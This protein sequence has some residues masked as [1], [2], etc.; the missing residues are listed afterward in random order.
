MIEPRELA[1]GV[2]LTA[3]TGAPSEFAGCVLFSRDGDSVETV[4]AC[5][6]VL[7][8][9]GRP[10][11][12]IDQEG[13]RVARIRRGVEALPSMMALGAIGDAE[14]ATRAGEAVAHDLRRA[15]CT[16]DF[17]P[18]L[19]LALEPENTVIG[20]RA[21]GS[22][23]AFVAR[24]GAAFARG[25]RNGGIVP[26][27]KHFPGHGST[28]I[29]S[30]LALPVIDI[31]EATL[32]ARDLAP[33]AAVAAH[34]DPIMVSHVVARALDPDRPASL[35]ARIIRG[36]LRDEWG[37]DG[38]VFTDCMQMDAIARG[39]GTVQ[40]V[41]AAIAAGAD[42]ALVSHVEALASAC[43]D[44]L[45]A[46]VESGSLAYE[47][48][49]EAYE[50]VLRLRRNS[51]AP[52]ALD[53]PAPHPGVGA[54]IARRAVTLV[55]GDSRADASTTVV[56]SFEGDTYDGA[57]GGAMTPSLVKYAP[58]GKEIRAALAPQAQDRE[59][60]LLALQA[61]GRR[62]VVLARRAHLYPEQAA[63]I[64]ALC[65]ANP[66]AIVISV[67]EPFDISCFVRA[68]HVMATYGDEDVSLRGLAEVLFGGVTARGVLPVHVA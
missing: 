64:D 67:R 62:P 1:R 43:V 45:V 32:R 27:Y 48:L 24:M 9:G 59:T 40:G 52:L 46:N 63:T 53:A 42:C 34:D 19:D 10:L 56:V 38:V 15:G 4:R 47:R 20:T 35:S 6:D 12:A 49:H 57:G 41:C 26:T 36:I 61:S 21:F 31:D 51:P 14:L 2:I 22:D 58:A 30:H 39:I 25:L 65:D 66:D 3:Y 68:R 37:F 55:R 29:D 50:R 23:P 7:R 5:S 28:A 16:L 18:V 8:R 13:G 17:A 11:V 60:L 44:A 54:E 33:F